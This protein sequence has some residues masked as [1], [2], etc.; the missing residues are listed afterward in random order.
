[1]E[2]NCLRKEGTFI[3]T[4]RNYHEMLIGKIPCKCNNLPSGYNSD[5]VWVKVRRIKLISIKT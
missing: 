4:I 2:R 5:E 3:T 1:M